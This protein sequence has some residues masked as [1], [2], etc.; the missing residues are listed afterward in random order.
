[1]RKLLAHGGPLSFSKEG[2]V[3]VHNATGRCECLDSTWH[4]VLSAPLTG[5]CDDDDGACKHDQLRL[6][7]CEA[8]ASDAAAAVVR[9]RCSSYLCSFLYE[10]ERN[11]PAPQRCG[12]L[13]TAAQAGDIDALLL[14]LRNHPSVPPSGKGVA[15]CS[16]GPSTS[17]VEGVL[18]LSDETADVSMSKLEIEEDLNVT[19]GSR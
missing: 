13:Y 17:D 2:F 3:S 12:P 11:K 10:R 6:L 19:K 14:A 1:M 16:A 5:N 18:E 7:C 9:Q 8:D 15:M 4:G